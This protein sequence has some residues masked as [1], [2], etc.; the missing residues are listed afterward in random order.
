M[1]RLLYTVL[2]ATALV[3]TG[4]TAF[5]QQAPGAERG[6]QLRITAVEGAL[7]RELKGDRRIRWTGPI[8]LF[9]VGGPAMLCGFGFAAF[10]R[11]WAGLEEEDGSND[12]TTEERRYVNRGLYVGAAGAALVAAGT[13]WT[14]RVARARNAR[15][16]RIR[17]LEQER[18]E[19][20]R[21]L[22]QP[23][24]TPGR[25]AVTLAIA[26]L[27]SAQVQGLSVALSF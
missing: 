14:V 8:T 24:A 21:R 3:M 4:K 18:R 5:A 9:A 25:G 13:V 1:C 15:N 7:E 27:L 6:V 16:L 2:I 22:V 23:F 26:P 19:L 10:A 20:S 12:Y 17:A 11:F